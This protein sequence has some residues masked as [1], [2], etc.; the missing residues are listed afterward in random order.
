MASALMPSDLSCLV[1]GGR[2]FSG[3]RLRNHFREG[4]HLIGVVPDGLAASG[5]PSA[6]TVQDVFQVGSHALQIRSV[7][8]LIPEHGGAFDGNGI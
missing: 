8:G 6:P 3:V 1:R 7:R 5:G 2:S 4:V